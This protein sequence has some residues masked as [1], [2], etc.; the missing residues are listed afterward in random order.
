[1]SEKIVVKQDD[2]SRFMI[3]RQDELGTE[4]FF[5]GFSNYTENPGTD[6]ESQ[7][8]GVEIWVDVPEDGAMTFDSPS[9][10]REYMDILPSGEGSSCRIVLFGRSEVENT[11]YGSK[12]YPLK[13][14]DRNVLNSELRVRP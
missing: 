4:K 10:A 13:E 14:W 11:F 2:G 1:M 5:G 8:Y 6:E 3:L 12:W 9:K 7:S